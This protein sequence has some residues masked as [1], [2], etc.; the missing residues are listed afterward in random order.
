MVVQ[1][2]LLRQLVEEGLKAGGYLPVGAAGPV[3]ARERLATQ[4]TTAIVVELEATS[5]AAPELIAEI[6][7]SDRG[8]AIPILGFC[9]HT[10]KDAKADALAA[11][12]DR[13][14]TRGEVA[15][16]LDRTVDQLVANSKLTL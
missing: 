16:R 13:V 14:I 5:F 4:E 1:D 6:R 8:A 11:G 10:N 3:R 15:A 12:C 2:L 7:A 9:G